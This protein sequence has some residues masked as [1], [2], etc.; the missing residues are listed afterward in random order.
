MESLII[1]GLAILGL[2]SHFIKKVIEAKQAGD[3]ITIKEYYISNPYKS[4]YSILICAGGIMML[5]GSDELTR[6]TAFTFGYMSDSVVA[7]MN[8]KT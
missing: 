5:W 7:M 6:V 1:I 3:P 4:I 2:L 8:R